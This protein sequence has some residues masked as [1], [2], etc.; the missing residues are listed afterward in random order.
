MPNPYHDME[1]PE[2][3]DDSRR[4]ILRTTRYNK[5]RWLVVPLALVIALLIV[6][7]YFTDAPSEI[8][9]YLWQHSS[10]NERID[11][12]REDFQTILE[13]PQSVQFLEERSFIEEQVPIDAS[14]LILPRYELEDMKL[15]HRVFDLVQQ[16]TGIPVPPVFT[17]AAM[18]TLSLSLVQADTLVARFQRYA[19]RCGSETNQIFLNKN[20]ILE[21][22]RP[23]YEEILRRK[24][25]Y[26]M[27]NDIQEL[28]RQWNQKNTIIKK[29]IR[30]FIPWVI[31]AL[32]FLIMY[33]ILR[34]IVL[35]FL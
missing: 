9:H 27:E 31:V 3:L 6:Q 12:M 8:T 15:Y 16:E 32:L 35:Q 13:S 19:V 5:F 14:I 21:K 11:T 23:L 25:R 4:K 7:L 22:D 30:K 29:L 24:Y 20:L 1:D 34:I 17:P 28:E 33:L 26:K 18:D 2:Y 10:E